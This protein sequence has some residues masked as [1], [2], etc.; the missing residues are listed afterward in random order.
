LKQLIVIP[1]YNTHIYINK[2]ISDLYKNTSTDILIIDD[3]S[4]PKISFEKNKLTNI[5]IIRNNKNR[6]KGHALKKGFIYA[7]ENNYTHVITLDGDLQHDPSEINNFILESQDI[8]FLIGY[9][10]LR[11]PMPLLRIISNIITSKIIS[12]ILNKRIRDSQC[13]YR[14]Y[15][16]KKIYFK[17]NSSNGYIFES[18]ILL[19]SV[20]KSSKLKNIPIKLIYDGSPS[21]INKFTDTIKFIEL[22]LKHIIA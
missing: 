6:G 1:C 19:N 15:C 11:K 14:R 20:N 5:K 7:N 10:E 22:I 13:G 16:L 8:D 21:H 18:E 9:R 3:G 17:E 2:L 12:L 4:S